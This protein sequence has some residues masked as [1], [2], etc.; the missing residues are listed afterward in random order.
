MHPVKT[1]SANFVYRGPTPDIGDL[2]VERR[3]EGR[4]VEVVSVWEPTEE[5][6]KIIAEGGRITLGMFH[7]PIPPVRIGVVGAEESEPVDEH[8]FKIPREQGGT[9]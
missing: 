4:A 7:E 5:E 3:P 8:G 1:S 6:R 9:L 2:W